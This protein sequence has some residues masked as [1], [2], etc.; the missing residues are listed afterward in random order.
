[1][2]VIE[3][4]YANGTAGIRL[5]VEPTRSLT[6]K[7]GYRIK[8][9]M[10]FNAGEAYKI[11]IDLDTHLRFYTVNGNDKKRSGLFVATLNKVERIVLRTGRVMRLPVADSPSDQDYD[12]PKGGE[13]DK[14]AV[15]YITSFKTSGSS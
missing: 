1:M 14:K 5:S 4:Q 15:Y 6:T 7:A 8:N 11:K 3:F 10:T 13:Q 12:L 9:L 2:L